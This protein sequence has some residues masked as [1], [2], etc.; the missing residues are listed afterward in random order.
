MK[1]FLLAAGQGTRLRPFTDHTPKCLMP[2]HGKPLLQIWIELLERHGI[3]EALINIHAHAEQVRR[4]IQAFQPKTGV[5]II[6][7]FEKEL[8]GSAGTLWRQRD[9]VTGEHS[10][11]I[12]Y[13]DNLTNLHLGTI[14]KAHEAFHRVGG[15]LTMGL[16]PSP[17]PTECGIVSLNTDSRIVSFIEK[18]T[19][20]IGNLANAGIYIASHQLYEFFPQEDE[21]TGSGI[22]DLGHHIL[23][24]L[25]GHMFGYPIRAYI[26]DI[27]SPESYL[28]AQREWPAESSE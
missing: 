4:W 5:R 17:N 1:A 18:P 13:A 24:R 15:I 26:R 2:V 28:A 10:F 12:A 8:L 21:I 16:F 3:E 6:P 22:L 11:V 7:F 27:G 25:V 20:P 9:F 23:P 14:M 19:H